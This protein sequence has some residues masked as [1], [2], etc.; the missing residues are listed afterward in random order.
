MHEENRPHDKRIDEEVA[1]GFPGSVPRTESS[2]SQLLLGT[3]RRG[4]SDKIAMYEVN[5][6]YDS[7]NGK[8]LAR[9]PLNLFKHLRSRVGVAVHLITS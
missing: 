4:G 3:D 2:G 7:T 9:I 1:P 5:P 8:I 6:I